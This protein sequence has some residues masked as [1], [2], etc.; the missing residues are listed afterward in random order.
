MAYQL[1][2]STASSWECTGRLVISFQSILGRCSG[3]SVSAVP[4]PP[5][6]GLRD[7]GK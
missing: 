5:A 2:F 4:A 7:G 1:S 3:F 6:Q